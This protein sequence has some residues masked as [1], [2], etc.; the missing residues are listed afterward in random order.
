ML[1]K[2][3]TEQLV[4]M[5]DH[6]TSA[7][8]VDQCQWH[9]PAAPTSPALYANRPRSLETSHQKHTTGWSSCQRCRKPPHLG[10]AMKDPICGLLCGSPS[11]M[12]V[13]CPTCL[14]VDSMIMPGSRPPLSYALILG[15][16]IQH[17]T[18]TQ[19]ANFPSEDVLPRRLAFWNGIPSLLL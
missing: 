5:V 17:H 8:Q 1:R 12:K 16:T 18:I 2:A 7:T 10:L 3:V 11:Y 19:L 4:C 13:S 9:S 14:H 15:G 6:K